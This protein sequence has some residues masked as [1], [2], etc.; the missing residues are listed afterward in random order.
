MSTTEF[1]AISA[2]PCDKCG[3]IERYKNRN[4]K[5]CTKI[6]MAAYRAANPGKAQA[7]MAVWR[8]ANPDR[9]KSI[10][11]TWHDANLEKVKAIKSAWAAANPN[12]VTISNAAWYAANTDKVNAYQAGWRKANPETVKI[13]SHN[14]RARERDAGGTLSKGLSAKLFKLQQGKCP[15]CAQLLGDDYHLDHIMPLVLGGTNMDSNIQL[16]RAKCNL[17]KNAKEPIQFMRQRGF[18]L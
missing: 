4:C 14:R 17:Q 6:R 12:K 2:R 10:K 3:T 7:D 8:A 18:L 15:C 13:Y 11:S 16:L 1:K 5:A 9:V